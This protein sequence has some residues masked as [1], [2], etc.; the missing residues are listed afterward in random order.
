MGDGGWEKY[1]C[2]VGDDGAEVKR[3]FYIFGLMA[4]RKVVGD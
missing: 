3:Y 4:G 1:Y 2:W